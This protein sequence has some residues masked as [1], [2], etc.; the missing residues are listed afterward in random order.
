M[1]FR[2]DS[3]DFD[4]AAVNDFLEYFLGEGFRYPFEQ[5]ACVHLG[6][7]FSGLRD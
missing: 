3:F 6:L 7:G 5:I 1:A 2:D 4:I